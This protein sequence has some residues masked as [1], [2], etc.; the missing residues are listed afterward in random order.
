MFIT[1]SHGYENPSEGSGYEP[2]TAFDGFEILAHPLPDRESRIFGRQENGN[3]GTCYRAY[4]LKLARKTDERGRAERSL[5]L[6]VEHGGGREVWSLRWLYDR[7][8]TL[9]ALLAMPERALY[10]VLW[11]LYQSAS[12]ARTQAENETRREW[13]QA[14]ADNRIRRRSYP[15]RGTLKIWMDPPRREGETDESYKRR[16]KFAAPSRGA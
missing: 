16:C 9:P 10:A 13:S 14:A 4:S 3:G 1:K 2:C 5:H 6:L 12:D 15:S 7:G 8:E 11:A